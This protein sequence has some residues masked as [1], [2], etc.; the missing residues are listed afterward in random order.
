MNVG[1]SRRTPC[2]S[3]GYLQYPSVK[4]ANKL[5][6]RTAPQYVEKL[7]LVCTIYVYNMLPKSPPTKANNKALYI[8]SLQKNRWHKLLRP[9]RSVLL[10]WLTT[11]LGGC[12]LLEQPSG[13]M[14]QFYPTFREMLLTHYL[15][16]GFQ[17]VQTLHAGVQL[18]ANC[19]YPCA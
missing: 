8:R 18:R 16:M 7:S 9:P 19:D 13:S 15:A 11:A 12:F 10:C 17:C 5:L 1:T 3:L 4:D 6:E 14:L 2:A